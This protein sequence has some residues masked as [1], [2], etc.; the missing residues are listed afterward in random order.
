M[1]RLKGCSSPVLWIF[2]GKP[3]EAGLHSVFRHVLNM[4]IQ[5]QM[6]SFISADIPWSPLSVRA[7]G[8]IDFEKLGINEGNKGEWQVVVRP[9]KICIG[10]YEFWKAPDFEVFDANIPPIDTDSLLMLREAAGQVIEENRDRGFARAVYSDSR[11]ADLIAKDLKAGY[12]NIGEALKFR[13]A[14]Q[15]KRACTSLLGA[16]PGLTP[17]GDDFLCGMLQMLWALGADAYGFKIKNIIAEA[18]EEKLYLTCD[19]SK[20]YLMQSLRGY[21]GEL[22]QEMLSAANEQECRECMVRMS[23]IGHSSGVDML[24]GVWTILDAIV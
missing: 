19:I 15:L 4:V 10:K 1:N 9:E 23:Q 20:A 5:G 2:S 12:L 11:D 3:A 13:N 21:A 7:E 22:T 14:S 18:I 24:C 17:S 8:I 16:G 6:I